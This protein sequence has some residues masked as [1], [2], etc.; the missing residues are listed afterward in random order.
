MEMRQLEMLIA[1]V[2]RKGY[3]GAGEFMHISHSAIHRQIR[4]LEEE[5]GQQI[6]VRSGKAAQLTETGERI[7]AFACKLKQE[8]KSLRQEIRDLQKLTGGALRIGTGTTVLLLFLPD[9]FEEFRRTYP[10]VEL[11]IITGTADSIVID[12][13]SG[14]LDIGLIS[15]LS[16]GWRAEKDVVYEHLYDE[17]FSL[18]VSKSHHLAKKKSIKWSELK[19]VPIIAFPRNS[20]IRR[21][22]DGF[23]QENGVI[24][25]VVMELENEEA[26]EKMIEVSCGA[27]FLARRRLPRAHMHRITVGDKKILLSNAGVRVGAY[28]PRRVEEFLRICRRHAALHS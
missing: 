17:E 10:G 12:L 24:P 11:Q 18:V 28:V 16:E 27:G 22:I 9:V 19:D 23:F 4:L 6:F 20:R 26:I 15:E 13:R 3:L 7:F 25:K 1:V 21:L 5:I 14:N 8:V 2:E